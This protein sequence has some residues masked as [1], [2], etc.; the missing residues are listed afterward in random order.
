[1]RILVLALA[2]VTVFFLGCANHVAFKDDVKEEVHETVTDASTEIEM[3]GSLI[4]DPYVRL[5]L[6][7]EQNIEARTEVTKIRMEEVTPYQGARELYE[8][9]LGIGSVPVSIVFHVLDTLLFGFIPNNFVNGYTNWA[10]VAMNPFMNA[11]NEKRIELR[12]LDRK[13]ELMRVD[14]EHVEFP[15]SR[16]AVTLQVDGDIERQAETDAKG[17]LEFHLLDLTPSAPSLPPRKLTIRVPGS[18]DVRES[19]RSFYV[20]RNL[21]MR[22]HEGAVHRDLL[23]GERPDVAQASRAVLALEELGFQTYA[24]HVEE[25]VYQA[26]ARDPMLAARFQELLAEASEPA[27]EGVEPSTPASFE[28]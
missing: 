25:R 18:D 8:V 14:R 2:S 13:T 17:R 5:Q 27:T 26:Y 1:M 12:E 19:E 7:N 4:V 22:L 16:H 28:D 23:L 6:I 15:L 24:R 21:S 9:P 3:E 20:N 10:F 11:E